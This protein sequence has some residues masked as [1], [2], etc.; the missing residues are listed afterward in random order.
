MVAQAVAAPQYVS[1]SIVN[2]ISGEILVGEACGES[3]LTPAQMSSFEAVLS[4]PAAPNEAL[5]AL[6]RSVPP[7]DIPN[8]LYGARVND[9]GEAV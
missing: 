7:W 8:R 3:L 9:D 2:Y 6:M 4:A 1:G 5:R